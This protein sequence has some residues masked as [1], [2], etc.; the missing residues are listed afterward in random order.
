MTVI[1]RLAHSWWSLASWIGVR[2]LGDFLQHSYLSAYGDTLFYFGRHGNGDGNAS[3]VDGLV[4]LTIDDGLCRPEIGDSMVPE[5]RLLLQRHGA[6]ATFFV[7]TDYTKPDEARSLLRDGH[8]L[9]NHLQRDACGHYHKLAKEDFR[10]E[11]R[12]ANAFLAR[13][14]DGRGTQTWFRAPQGRMTREMAEVVKEEGMTHVLGDCY[15]DDWCFA[16]AQDGVHPR[17]GADEQAH[18]SDPA[19]TKERQ[20]PVANLMLKQVHAGGGSILILHMQQQGFWEAG[21]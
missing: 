4:A 19:E 17:G 5:I 20:S 6:R 11:V 13:A 2:R 3:S 9:G 10:A 16:E 18:A 7:C 21:C 14:C 1:S 15:C 8:E 12:A